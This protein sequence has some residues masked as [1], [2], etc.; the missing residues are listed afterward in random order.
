VGA[1]VRRCRCEGTDLG[2]DL[3]GGSNGTHVTA[4]VG[5]HLMTGPVAAHTCREDAVILTEAG[6]ALVRRGDAVTQT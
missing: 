2:N 6:T 5:K 1:R 3:S 4:D